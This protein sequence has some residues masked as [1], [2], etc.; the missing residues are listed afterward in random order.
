M[1]SITLIIIPADPEEAMIL[2]TIESIDDATNSDLASYQALVAGDVEALDLHG[3]PAIL[4][5][6]ANGKRLNLPPNHRA[7]AIAQR[8]QAALHVFDF[9]VGDAFVTGPDGEGN[10]SLS[11]GDG[12]RLELVGSLKE[13][14]RLPPRDHGG[15]YDWMEALSGGWRPVGLWGSDGW[16]LGTW[17]YVIVACYDGDGVSAFV[18]YVEGDIEIRS[19]TTEEVRDREI[20]RFAVEHWNHHDVEGAPRT[21]SDGRLGRYNGW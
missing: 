6:N 15:G 13:I 4:W 8:H 5:F 2:R 17:P 16:N 14:P 1:R 18:V 9:I 12:Y 7:T 10:Q 19:F 21:L 20:D 11:V 3:P